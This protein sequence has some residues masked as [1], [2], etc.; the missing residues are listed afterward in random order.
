MTYKRGFKSSGYGTLAENDLKNCYSQIWYHN[1]ASPN[2][3]S[4]NLKT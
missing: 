1:L 2:R 3:W 4:V